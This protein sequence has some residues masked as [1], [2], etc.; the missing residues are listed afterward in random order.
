[1]PDAS[2]WDDILNS[3]DNIV[4]NNDQQIRINSRLFDATHQSLQQL[5]DVIGK[6]NAIDGDLHLF[7]TLLHKAMILATQLAEITRACQLA[8]IAVV[9]TNMLDHET[10]LIKMP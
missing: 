6:V 10:S 7:T 1:M 5:N 3:Q 4:R 2:E 9:N 8:K